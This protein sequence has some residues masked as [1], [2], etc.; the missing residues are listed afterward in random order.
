[1]DKTCLSYWYPL[2]VAEVPTPKTIIIE[3]GCRLTSILDGQKPECLDKLI[4]NIQYAGNKLGWPCFLRTGFGSDKHH[5]DDTCFL[6]DASVIRQHIYNLVEWSECV[7]FIG[8]P[9]DIWVVRELLPTKP[10]F[11]AFHNMPICR[12]FRCFIKDAEIQ[13]IHPYWPK[14]VL[15]EQG[16]RGSAVTPPKWEEKYEKLL[17]LTFSEKKDIE[18]LASTVGSVVGG[19]WSID[20]LDTERGWYVTDM[21]VADQSWHWPFCE[22]AKE[23]G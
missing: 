2:I 22:F 4:D 1:M 20:I 16:W 6:K 21:A 14:D 18:I 7:S 19:E 3:A 9:Y 17:S 23:R 8:L 12:E 15:K 10:V 11:T 13:C 5:W